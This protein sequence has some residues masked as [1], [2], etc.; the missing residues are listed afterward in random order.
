MLYFFGMN[1]SLP[2]TWKK[3]FFI[4]IVIN[5]VV[6]YDKKRKRIWKVSELQGRGRKFVYA[7]EFIYCT[8]AKLP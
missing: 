7:D 2:T 1:F 6:D 5:F 4:S 8:K 3:E